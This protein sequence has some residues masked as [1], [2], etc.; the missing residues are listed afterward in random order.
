MEAIQDQY[1]TRH[2]PDGRIVFADHRIST[3]LGYLPSEVVGLSAFNFILGEDLPWTAMAQRHSKYFILFV[4]YNN[5]FGEIHKIVIIFP[6]PT[7]QEYKTIN[8]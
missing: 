5:F 4:D 7:V 1:I 8:Y 2:L 3:I 6:F